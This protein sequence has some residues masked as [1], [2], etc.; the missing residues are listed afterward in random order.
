MDSMLLGLMSLI[1]LPQSTP[2]APLW[3][4][5]VLKLELSIGTPSITN[6]GW[7]LPVTEFT[8]LIRILCDPP[9]FP[10]GDVILTPATFPESALTALL[11]CALFK[12]SLSTLGAEKA[13]AFSFLVIPKAVTTTSSSD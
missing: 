5:V 9:K 12:L 11:F 2:P 8:P 13:N 10:E 7:L 1:A 3:V 4:L 6:N